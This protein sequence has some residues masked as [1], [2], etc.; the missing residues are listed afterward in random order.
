ME[1]TGLPHDMAIML[2]ELDLL[3]AEIK[4]LPI[5]SDSVVSRKNNS[6]TQ[7]PAKQSEPQTPRPN[8]ADVSVSRLKSFAG[9]RG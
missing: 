9:R 5:P 1:Q 3:A 2:D 8:V 6:A 7:V 4:G